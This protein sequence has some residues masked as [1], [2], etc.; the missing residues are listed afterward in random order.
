M[1]CGCCAASCPTR[2][3]EMVEGRPLILNEVCIK[4]GCCGFQCPRIELPK[5]VMVLE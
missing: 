5:N 2:A 3:I 1:G 4:C